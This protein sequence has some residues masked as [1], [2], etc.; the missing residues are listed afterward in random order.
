M[1][2]VANLKELD[3]GAL[4]SLITGYQA[5]SR[6]VVRK[7]ETPERIE[8]ILER[9]DLA[10]SFVKRY[11]EPDESQMKLYRQAVRSGFSLGAFDG[12]EM[13]GVAIAEP[14][15]WNSTLGVWEFHVAADYRGQG[16]GRQLMERLIEKARAAK[17]RAIVC[18]TQTT[19][20]LAVAFYRRMGFEID[21]IDLSYYTNDDLA[22]G[23]V[24]IFMKRKL[25]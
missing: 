23:E 12:D 2:R 25:L 10:K 19:N 6:F 3:E 8:F 16:I 24:A 20:T 13:V 21:G 22:T 11:D 7:T 17:L 14:Q 18:E 4:K 15:N 9:A 5:T 1:I